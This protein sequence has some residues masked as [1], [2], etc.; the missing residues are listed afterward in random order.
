MAEFDTIIRGGMVV[1][2]TRS[3]RYR[4]DVGIRDGRVEGRFEAVGTVPGFLDRLRARG[5]EVDAGIFAAGPMP[6]GTA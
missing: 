4:A 2:G 3:P 6:E 5:I 1:D